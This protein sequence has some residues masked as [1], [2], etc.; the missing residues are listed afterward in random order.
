MVVA[1]TFVLPMM[2]LKRMLMVIAPSTFDVVDGTS[3]SYHFTWV[4]ISITLAGMAAIPLMLMVLF[5]IVPILS[6]DEIEEIE[7]AER[8]AGAAAAAAF[9][10]SQREQQHHDEVEVED[11]ALVRS[12]VGTSARAAGVAGALLLAAF[13]GV[14]GL[15]A[16]SPAQAA[17]APS[18]PSIVLSAHQA[19]RTDAPVV[20]TAKVQDRPGHPVAKAD[21]TFQLG[22][23]V[24][25]PRAV[26]IGTAKTNAAGVARLTL[27]GR[28]AVGYHPTATGPQEFIA[29]YTPP[30]AEAIQSSTNIDVTAARSAYTPAPAKPLDPLGSALPKALF[31]IVGTVWTLLIIQ[32]VRVRRACRP[33]PIREAHRV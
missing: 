7:E 22:S 5:R 25:G 30:G 14:F 29:S 18:G 31:L 4:S 28:H 11:P 10:L 19:S 32:V 33:V 3:G 9:L 20:L 24:F 13:L 1:A 6:I 17:A 16:K 12:G 23:T 15:G 8:E 2:W 26:D 21:V 27:G